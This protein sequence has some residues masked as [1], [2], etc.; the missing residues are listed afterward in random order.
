MDDR[1]NAQHVINVGPLLWYI[2]DIGIRFENSRESR[3]PST[4]V[5][6]QVVIWVTIM[7]LESSMRDRTL[8]LKAPPFISSIVRGQH[9][10]GAP[11]SSAASYFNSTCLPK[12]SPYF[13][14][15]FNN[16]YKHLY[17]TY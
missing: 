15:F 13:S 12:V 7:K 6:K 16:R 5:P 11:R 9:L 1:I 14:D 3:I 17:C 8:I 10:S 2:E 4:I